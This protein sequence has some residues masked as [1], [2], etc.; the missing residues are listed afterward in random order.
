MDE[1]GGGA[2][3]R[4]AEAFKRAETTMII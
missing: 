4:I 2:R 1:Q 3:K